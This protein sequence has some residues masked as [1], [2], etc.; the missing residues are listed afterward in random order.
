MTPVKANRV[1]RAFWIK[2]KSHNWAMDASQLVEQL[3]PTPEVSS[4]NPVIGQIS[5]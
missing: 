2:N 4:L 5:Y 1:G 3:L